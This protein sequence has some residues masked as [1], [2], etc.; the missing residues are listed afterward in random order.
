MDEKKGGEGGE[1]ET[2]KLVIPFFRLF[3]SRI[4]G[5]VAKFTSTGTK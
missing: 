3:N 2:Q 5:K 1:R 4:C